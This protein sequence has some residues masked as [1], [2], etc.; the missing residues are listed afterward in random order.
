MFFDYSQTKNAHTLILLDFTFS[1]YFYC[2]IYVHK[3]KVQTI[4]NK[5]NIRLVNLIFISSLKRYN[6]NYTFVINYYYRFVEGLKNL[7][8]CIYYVC[9]RIRELVNSWTSL[10]LIDSKMN[11]T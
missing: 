4:L 2:N 5:N 3:L 8:C 7:S 6:F 10:N 9:E 1:I 11:Q